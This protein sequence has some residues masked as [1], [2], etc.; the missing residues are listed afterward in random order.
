MGNLGRRVGFAV[1]AIPAAAAIV[2]LGGVALAA[3]LA[4]IAGLAAWEF[5]GRP[6]RDLD[7]ARAQALYQE[8]KSWRRVARLMH[9]PLSTL[10]RR[11]AAKAPV[12]NSQEGLRDGFGGA[13]PTWV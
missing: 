4:L 6:T 9:V 11:M 10:H 13:V 12:K 5:L 7:G 8:T 1:I 2:W 3:L